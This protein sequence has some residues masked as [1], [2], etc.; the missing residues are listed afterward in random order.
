MRP[1]LASV[2]FT[3][4]ALSVSSGCRTKPED[5][6]A[7]QWREIPLALEN[8]RRLGTKCGRIEKL[9]WK[10]MQPLRDKRKAAREKDISWL[11]DEDNKDIGCLFGKVDEAWHEADYKLSNVR[12][13]RHEKG[14]VGVVVGRFADPGMP[15]GPYHGEDDAVVTVLV[16]EDGESVVDVFAACWC[17]SARLWRWGDTLTYRVMTHVSGATYCAATWDGIY[18]HD[19]ELG[20]GKASQVICIGA[21]EHVVERSVKV[22][23]AL[24]GVEMTVD[25]T[26]PDDGEKDAWASEGVGVDVRQSGVSVHRI[27]QFSVHVLLPPPFGAPTSLLD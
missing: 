27:S 7:G 9:M 21:S 20:S 14:S 22:A 15:S 11:E 25:V 19:V 5:L 24:H 3:T 4:I 13:F 6:S 8:F 23:V 12:F 26:H 18:F 1:A 10:T 16:T 2:V 17:H